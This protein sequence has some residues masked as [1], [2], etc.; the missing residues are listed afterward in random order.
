MGNTKS[1]LYKQTFTSIDEKHASIKVSQHNKIYRQMMVVILL[2]LSLC[3]MILSFCARYND[4][5]Q[6]PELLVSFLIVSCLYFILQFLLFVSMVKCAEGTEPAIV[7]LFS[8]MVCT[9]L[10]IILAS[11]SKYRIDNEE[12]EEKT[13]NSAIVFSCLSCFFSLI[14]FI[15]VIKN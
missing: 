10:S 2:L 14:C 13:T 1:D 15:L 5:E 12:D 8:A 7:L 11:I 6:K 3:P 9:I 4:E